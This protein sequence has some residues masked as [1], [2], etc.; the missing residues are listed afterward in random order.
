MRD[1][2]LSSIRP[3]SFL[4]AD[5][6]CLSCLISLLL[7]FCSCFFL[8]F[9]VVCGVVL[10]IILM[11]SSRFARSSVASLVTLVQND[12]SASLVVGFHPFSEGFEWGLVWWLWVRSV[13]VVHVMLQVTYQWS[14]LESIGSIGL[15]MSV[16]P[17]V[18]R[19]MN[20]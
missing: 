15:W 1:S 13:V 18:P 6:S 17:G 16:C 8:D 11:V 5:S 4:W 12:S 14:D 7:S 19:G 20:M 2:G 10:A 9:V 3:A